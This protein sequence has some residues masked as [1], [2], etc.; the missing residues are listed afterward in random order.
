GEVLG[1]STV[2]LRVLDATD[3][4]KPV[5]VPCRVTVLDAAG[6]L[7]TVG[8]DPAMRSKEEGGGARE[9]D[10][11]AVRPGV[12]YTGDGR[13][14]FG[15]PAGEYTIY[16]GR[17]FEYGIDKVKVSLKPGDVV[18]KELAIRR[19]VPTPG[20]VACDPHIHSLTYSGHGDATIGERV[21]AIAGE[22]VELPVAAEH[23]LHAD[24]HPAAVARGVRRHFTPVVGNEVTTP[25]GHFNI[26]PVSADAPVPEHRAREWKPIFE[27][28]VLRTGAEVIILNHPRDL[29]SGFRPFGPEHHNAATGENLDGWE[30]RAGAM[31]VVNSGAQQSD[32]LLPYRDWFALLNRGVFLTPVGASDSHD[33]ARFIVG[34]GR[35]YVRCNDDDPGAIDVKEAVASFRAGRVLVSCGLLA[36]ITVNGEHG[37]GD[38]APPSEE[39]RVAVRVLGPG[40]ARAEKVELYANGRKIREAEIAN[41]DRPGVKWEGEWKLPRFRHDVHLAAIATGPG[42]TE[43]YWPIAKP[44]QPASPEAR[45]RVIGSTGAVWIDADGDG[46]RT[47]A[48]AYARRLDQQHG[49]DTAALIRELA[50]YDGAVAAQ[51]AGLLQARGVSVQDPEVRAAAAKAGGQVARGFQVFFEAWRESEIARSR[52]R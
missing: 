29:H 45:R 21:L 15:L 26:F 40:W 11:L 14:R 28:I 20:Y 31:E 17:G 18:R 4:A 25:V 32:V 5:P 43:L 46:E 22:G 7:R 16:A 23:N 37:P 10:R 39:V 35:T 6:A 1:E 30:L 38:L 19:E 2:E 12:I 51:A 8:A 50:D 34:Q 33:V 41:G 52:A 9:R 13:A 47:S 48:F 49:K 42:V 24:Y 44:Y 36:E 27:S 3:A